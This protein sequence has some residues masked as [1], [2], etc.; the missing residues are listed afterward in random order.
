MVGDKENKIKD[1][2]SQLTVTISFKED[3]VWL[4]DEINTH[5]C[6]S[7]WIK[8]ILIKVITESM[9]GEKNMSSMKIQKEMNTNNTNVDS[10]IG[11]MGG[12]L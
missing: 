10:S 2:K 5:S 4:Y 9:Y 1:K 12:I 7:A 11:I 3:E 6:K 8:E